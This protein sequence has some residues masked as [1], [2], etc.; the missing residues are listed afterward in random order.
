MGLGV[1][2]VRADST[3]GASLAWTSKDPRVVEARQLVTRGELA[4]ADKLLVDDKSD[5]AE[6]MREMIRRVPARARRRRRVGAP[7]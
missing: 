1:A 5:A 6:E 3:D 7:R 2:S 4:K